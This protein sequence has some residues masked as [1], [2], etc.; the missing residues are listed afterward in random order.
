MAT[1]SAAL[2]ACGSLSE[3]QLLWLNNNRI[4]N[5][6]VVALARALGRSDGGG[7]GTSSSFTTTA[8]SHLTD[9][10][11]ESNLIG[12][13]GMEA[14]CAAMAKGALPRIAKLYLYQNRIG[15]AGARALA[16]ASRGSGFNA[17][18]LALPHFTRKLALPPSHS[19]RSKCE[20][21]T[22]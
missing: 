18:A 10:N 20:T 8:L 12:D 16:A 13:H 6:G 3:L 9:L 15:P 4:G 19:R 22:L 2:G 5:R 7:Q 14:L 1:L 17:A 21:K 11:L